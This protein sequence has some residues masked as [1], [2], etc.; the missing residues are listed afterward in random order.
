MLIV[1]A[2]MKSIAKSG[3]WI[4]KFGKWV[5]EP[6]AEAPS[7]SGVVPA[8]VETA[9]VVDKGV[10]AVLDTAILPAK[11]ALGAAKIAVGVA[12]TVAKFPLDVAAA[13][14]GRGQ[15]QSQASDETT[16]EEKA[17]EKKRE[18]RDAMISQLMRQDSRAKLDNWRNRGFAGAPQIRDDAPADD[19]EETSTFR[20]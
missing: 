5:F 12:L 18:L 19:V 13:A 8:I 3:R 4:K 11:L 15:Q 20:V 2:A 14:A 17:R 7:F 1:A 10:N 6:R 9:R 16:E